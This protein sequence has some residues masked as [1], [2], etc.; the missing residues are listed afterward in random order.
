MA[1]EE[2]TGQ[3]ADWRAVAEDAAGPRP[4]EGTE[5][6][7]PIPAA[8]RSRSRRLLASRPPRWMGVLA[9][10]AVVGIVVWGPAS[11]IRTA[12]TGPTTTWT[13]TDAEASAD[14]TTQPT[15]PTTTPRT[16]PTS[17]PGQTPSGPASGSAPPGAPGVP[18]PMGT[19]PL[20]GL[21]APL[22]NLQRPALVS[23]I[24]GSLPAMPQLGL[25]VADL[26]IEVKV[27]W[28]SR[29]L[30]VW[31]FRRRGGDRPRALGPHDGPGP[32]GHVRPAPVRLLGIQP[33]GGLRAGGHHVGDRRE[34]P[35]GARRLLP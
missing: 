12:G 8:P 25:E 35:Q 13:D 27:E 32:A 33:R 26:V 17:T 9:L 28:G 21:P 29:Y 1:E 6:P 10:L 11:G 30:G 7:G 22:S 4:A 16:A 18:A 15:T 5:I 2:P 19:A 20:T 24:D 3:R 31:H 14:S 34:P 23:K